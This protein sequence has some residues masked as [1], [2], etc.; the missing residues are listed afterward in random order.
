MSSKDQKSIPDLGFST[1]EDSHVMIS[2]SLS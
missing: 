1:D 2:E